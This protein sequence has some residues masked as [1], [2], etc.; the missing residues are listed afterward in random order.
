MASYYKNPANQYIEKVSYPGIL[1]LFLGCFFFAF[2]GIWTHFV[3]SLAL[4]V[5]TFGLSWLIYPFF[6]S[7][8]VK[9]HYQRNGW[10]EIPESEVKKADLKSSLQ[11]LISGIFIF[12]IIIFGIWI[13]TELSIPWY[14]VFI[15][16]VV[17]AG[18]PSA[19]SEMKDDDGNE[20]PVMEKVMFAIFFM[21]FVSYFTLIVY[22]FVPSEIF[23]WWQSIIGV[24]AC[25]MVG[26]LVIGLP[27]AM[28]THD[29][30]PASRALEV[31]TLLIQVFV[32]YFLLVFITSGNNFIT[33][34]A[35]INAELI[36]WKNLLWLFVPVIILFVGM[37]SP[38]FLNN[39]K[40]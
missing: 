28:A 23:N 16:L 24:F 14:V 31:C 39:A 3:I 10:T 40:K 13:S 22:Y 2:R 26:C 8:I 12:S 29:K 32:N 17:L 21:I 33:G 37:F 15:P 6:A 1:T 5:M 30:N 4:A 9:K 20:S 27:F 7:G 11:E 34:N 18:I 25:F 36:W 35:L 19:F 38:A